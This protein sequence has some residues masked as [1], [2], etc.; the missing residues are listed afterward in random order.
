MDGIQFNEVFKLYMQSRSLK[1][2]DEVA[3]SIVDAYDSANESASLTQFA[4]KF[5]RSS[6]SNN[7]IEDIKKCLELNSLQK[8]K[9]KELETSWI[10]LAE[11]FGRYWSASEFTE[12]PTPSPGM[13]PA[14]GIAVFNTGDTITL[15]K[16]LKAA[17]TSGDVDECSFLLTNALIN[18]QKTLSGKYFGNTNGSP[19]P[20]DWVGVFSTTADKPEPKEIGLRMVVPNGGIGSQLNSVKEFEKRRQ[21]EYFEWGQLFSID[22]TY[23]SKEFTSNE[24]ARVIW[25][26]ELKFRE[27]IPGNY[28]SIHNHPPDPIPQDFKDNSFYNIHSSPSAADFFFMIYYSEYEMRVMD[29]IYIYIIQQPPSGHISLMEY[30]VQKS[31][32]KDINDLYEKTYESE[33]TKYRNDPQLIQSKWETVKAHMTNDVYKFI[34]Y[35]RGGTHSPNVNISLTISHAQATEAAA[36]AVA[37]KYNLAY[38][39]ISRKELYNLS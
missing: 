17:L 22:G 10:N 14:G 9:S 3:N 23:V 5:R 19:T 38:Q 21:F 8:Q 29:L 25:P 26:I 2:I 37:K 15:A 28:I 16:E 31:V 11:S 27:I 4:N 12:L 33:Y 1:D 39:K 20:V 30:S 7:L 35:E 32:K 34:F 13:V 36:R 24:R 6:Y 18:H